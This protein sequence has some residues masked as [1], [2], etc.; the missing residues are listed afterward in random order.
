VRSRPAPRIRSA[1][2][3]TSQPQP[4]VLLRRDNQLELSCM[5]GGD[6]GDFSRDRVVLPAIA[7]FAKPIPQITGKILGAQ[8]ATKNQCLPTLTKTARSRK[9]SFA[10]TPTSVLKS[11]RNSIYLPN[12]DLQPRKRFW[13]FCRFAGAVQQFIIRFAET[14]SLNAA[15]LGVFC[16]AF[17]HL[18]T[19]N[20][21][22]V[23]NFR[24]RLKI[25]ARNGPKG[26]PRRRSRH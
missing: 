17:P 13:T 4:S 19:Y 7:T 10:Y 21:H 3:L 5:M 9:T 12:K 26:N 6:I 8:L 16:L 25:R 11:A 24:R 14:S 18:A 1:R 20:P 15:T 2:S 22:R 23:C